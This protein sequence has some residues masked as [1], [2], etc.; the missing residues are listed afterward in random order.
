MKKEKEVKRGKKIAN[1]TVGRTTA[2]VRRLTTSIGGSESGQVCTHILKSQC[3]RTFTAQSP[4]IVR[5]GVHYYTKCSTFAKCITLVRLC[6]STNT[7]KPLHILQRLPSHYTF[8]VV[9]CGTFTTQNVLEIRSGH[10]H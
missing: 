5:S 10:R 9:A 6:P 1:S 2:V 8:Y 4:Y 7:T 3:P